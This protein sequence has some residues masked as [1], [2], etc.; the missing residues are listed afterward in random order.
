MSEEIIKLFGKVTHIFAHRFVVQGSRGA[1]LADLT[2]HGAELVDL[3]IGAE[4]ELEGE[5]KPSELKVTRFA[6]A[7]RS[8]TIAH[9]KKLDHPHHEPADPVIALE[10]VRAAGFKPEGTPH[11]KP[12]H[13]EIQA[14]RDGKGYELHVEL[15]GRIRKTKPAA[16]R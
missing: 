7:G 8:V 15:D 9:K 13:F 1:V 10:A 2:P 12:K 6:S 4:V 11:R 16:E 14:C 3:R 5:K